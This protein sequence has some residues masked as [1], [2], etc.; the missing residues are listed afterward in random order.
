MTSTLR[1]VRLLDRKPGEPGREEKIVAGITIETN[2]PLPDPR[3]HFS[4]VLEALLALQVNE[5]FH[6]MRHP[7][8]SLHSKRVK[9]TGRTF[10]ARDLGAGKGWRVW[11]LT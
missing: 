6:T 1:T 9:K 10:T 11:R 2:V 3:G 4:P 5:S 8:S 7:R